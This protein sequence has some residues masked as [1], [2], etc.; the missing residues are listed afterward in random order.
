[1]IL[2]RLYNL[3]LTYLK[4]SKAI[5]ILTFYKTIILVFLF[6]ILIPRY[7][8]YGAIWAVFFSNIV[9]ALIFQRKARELLT[10]KLNYGAIIAVF[11]VVFLIGMISYWSYAEIDIAIFG[12]LQFLLIIV[13]LSVFIYKK[14]ALFKSFR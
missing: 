8:L 3:E 14:R 5:S 10:L 7:E 6:V 11:I 2:A 13:C 4:E 12:A 1:M 9:N